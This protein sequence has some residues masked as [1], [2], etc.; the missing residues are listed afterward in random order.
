MKKLTF[1]LGFAVLAMGILEANPSYAGV[2]SVYH[3]VAPGKSA[4]ALEPEV[5]LSNGAGVAANLKY[6]YGLNELSNVQAILGTGSGPRRFR[7]GGN[8][9][10]DFFPDVQGQP[11]MGIAA[12]ALYY[13]L[14]N[15]GQL[16]L[17][18]IPYIHKAYPMADG[19]G[20][21]PFA[22][23]PAGIGFSD[24]TYRGLWQFV[25]GGMFKMTES[26]SYVV[27]L[28][29]DISNTESYVSGGIIYYF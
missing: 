22:A 4:A 17:T 29:V 25:V 23:L 15:N 8:M 27:E 9:N 16:E 12:Q 7:I 6:T 24:G 5:T 11:G 10:F 2:F 28:G 21:E 19:H 20:I 13:R 14:E 3:F 26:F 1:V 18:G